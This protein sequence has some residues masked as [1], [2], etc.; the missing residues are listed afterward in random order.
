MSAPKTRS[1]RR[2]WLM[3]SEPESFSFDDLFAARKHRSGWDGVRNHQARNFMRDDM[4]VGDGVLFYHSSAEPPG[5]AGV[6]RIARAAY[7]DPS[8][9]D[10]RSEHFD[11]KSSKAAPTWL[12]VDVEAVAACP[13]FVPLAELR[14]EPALA[15]MRLLQRGQRLS[16]LPVSEPE[17]RAVLALAGFAK[18]PS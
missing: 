9:F 11:A 17:W 10:R 12:Q 3:K 6:A 4:S 14:A 18:D 2:Y 1:A 7:P 16:I 13:R 15:G 8:Q 5:V